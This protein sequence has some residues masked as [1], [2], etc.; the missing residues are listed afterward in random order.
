MRCGVSGGGFSK[1]SQEHF[2]CSTARNKGATQCTNRLAIRRDTLEATVLDG[3]RHRLMDPGLFK[4][5]V[6]EFTAEWNRQQAA[7]SGTQ[8]TQRNELAQCAGRSNAS[9]THWRT[10]RRQRR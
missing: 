4:L 9:W 6:T 3:L 2:G 8:D 1:I 10:A 7:T 5:F